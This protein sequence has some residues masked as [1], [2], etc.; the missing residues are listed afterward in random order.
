[1]SKA[2]LLK[3]LGALFTVDE[4]R[5]LIKNVAEHDKRKRALK[6]IRCRPPSMRVYR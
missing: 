2:Q 6:K 4:L 5:E 3:R 1:M